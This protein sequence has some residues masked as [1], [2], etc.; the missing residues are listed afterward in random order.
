MEG[1]ERIEGPNPLEKE[2][3]DLRCRIQYLI[4]VLMMKT[5]VIQHE[6]EYVKFAP[7]FDMMTKGLISIDPD[8]D[9]QNARR[10]VQEITGI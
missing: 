5:G 3:F 7:V 10:K 2:I 4:I 9:W 6:M 1:V 8:L